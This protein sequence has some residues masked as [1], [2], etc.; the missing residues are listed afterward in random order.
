MNTE[1]L[2]RLSFFFGILLLISLAEWRWPKRALRQVKSRRWVGNFA[3]VMLNNIAIRVL[4]P[5]GAVGVAVIAAHEKWGLF[6]LITLPGWAEI[7][8]SV[9]LLD[10]AIYL[11]HVVFHAVPLFWRLHMVHHADQDIDVST[12][13]RFHTIE[14]LLSMGI[15]MAI[16]LL[17]GAPVLSVIIFEILL[18]A[19]SMFN[20]GNIELPLWMDRILRLLLVTPDMHRIHHS[21]IPKETNSNF[22]FNLPWWDR[23][24]GTYQAQPTKGH[25]DMDIGL[26]QFQTEKSSEIVW[27]LKIPFVKEQRPPEG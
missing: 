27:M 5:L 7:L 17:L 15:K 19:T 3:L 25:Q 2:F 12:G 21:T 18:N 13:I 4:I 22:G 10:L 14:I 24:F 6:N 26:S 23:L 16:V 9:L 11:Q 1:A 8:L 20:H